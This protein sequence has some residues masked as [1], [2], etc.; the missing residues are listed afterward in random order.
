M[1]FRNEKFIDRRIY[2]YIY[3]HAK[4]YRK[5][6]L[7]RKLIFNHDQR[8]IKGNFFRSNIYFL[9]L[10]MGFIYPKVYAI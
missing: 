5:H 8:L 6:A 4:S 3:I 9:S 2:I 7:L 10:K 1:G